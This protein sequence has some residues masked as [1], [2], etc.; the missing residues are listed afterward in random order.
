MN[1]HLNLH[2]VTMCLIDW[3]DVLVNIQIW[4]E[5]FSPLFCHLST[6]TFAKKDMCCWYHQYH[7]FAFANNILH[8]FPL[9]IGVLFTSTYDFSHAHSGGKFGKYVWFDKIQI[10]DFISLKSVTNDKCI[11]IIFG[12]VL[13]KYPTHKPRVPVFGHFSLT[14]CPP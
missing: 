9:L 13:S 11:F 5:F 2:F 4:D 10:H 8:G 1:V 7:Y 3:Y 14:T 6:P 12:K